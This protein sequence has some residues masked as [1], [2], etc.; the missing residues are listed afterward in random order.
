MR[1]RVCMCT[2]ELKLIACVFHVVLFLYAGMNRLVVAATIMQLC[3]TRWNVQRAFR[4]LFVLVFCS[5]VYLQI[6][7]SAQQLRTTAQ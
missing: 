6:S 5:L 3:S 4:V 1:V 7:S 2:C